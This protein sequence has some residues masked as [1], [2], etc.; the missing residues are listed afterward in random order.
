M[1]DRTAFQF[2]TRGLDGLSKKRKRKLAELLDDLSA[3]YLGFPE[4]GFDSLPTDPFSIDT[5]QWTEVS[6][7]IVQDIGLTGFQRIVARLQKWGLDTEGLAIWED[8]KYEW[9]GDMIRHIGGREV[10]TPCDSEGHALLV[11]AQIPES[12]MLSYEALGRLV[13]EYFGI[14]VRS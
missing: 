2:Y 11:Q 5:W 13:A 10:W 4:S 1:G 14:E 7:G 8:P 6:C 12:A 3:G 9:L